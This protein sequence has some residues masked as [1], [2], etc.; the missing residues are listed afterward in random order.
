MIAAWLSKAATP[1]IVAGL[2]LLAAALIGWATLATVKSLVG[3]ARASAISERDT[4]WSAEIAKSEAATQKLIADR[5]KETMA[6]QEAARAH[7]ASVEAQLAQLETDNAALPN[8]GACGLGRDR[9]RL[10]T[11]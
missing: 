2:V 10:L 9:V 6:A 4:H 7:V 8:D 1:L 5:L 3:D 11:R